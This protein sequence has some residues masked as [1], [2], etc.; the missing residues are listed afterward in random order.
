MAHRVSFTGIAV[1]T[2]GYADLS[3]KF[4]RDQGASTF[5]LDGT[6]RTCLQDSLIV[7]SRFAGAKVVQTKVY[8]DL[9][10]PATWVHETAQVAHGPLAELQVGHAVLYAREVVSPPM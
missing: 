5:I 10:N 7:A 3:R 1:G 2:A 8:Q 6:Q 4:F 9:V